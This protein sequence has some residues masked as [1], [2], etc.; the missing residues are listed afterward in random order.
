M[1]T[2]EETEDLFELYLLDYSSLETKVSH[3]QNRIESAEALVLLRLDTQRNELLTANTSLTILSCA[4]AMG[5]YFTGVFGMNLDNTDT[6]QHVKGVFAVVFSS[7]FLA[8]FVMFFTI[9]AFF[10]YKGVLK[11]TTRPMNA[12]FVCIVFFY[13]IFIPAYL[14]P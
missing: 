3:L 6:I 9:V 14:F 8:I 1:N 7:S 13:I 10:E 4:I 5:A 12:A 11:I 2:H